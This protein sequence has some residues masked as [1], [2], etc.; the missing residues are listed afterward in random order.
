MVLP[1]CLIKR[2][3][4]SRLFAE[5]T[6][7]VPAG[8]K[9]PDLTGMLFCI[10]KIRRGKKSTNNIHRTSKPKFIPPYREETS[11]RTRSKNEE[12]SCVNGTIVALDGCVCA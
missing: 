8:K 11:I 3:L 12:I 4:Q 6:I 5:G 2:C 9:Q 1:K 7:W 10:Y